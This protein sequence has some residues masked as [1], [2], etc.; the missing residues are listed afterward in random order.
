MSRLALALV[1]ALL[2]ADAPSVEADRALEQVATQVAEAHRKADAQTD[3][4]E[5]AKILQGA[6]ALT[7]PQAEESFHLR[8]D[9]FAQIA[10]LHLKSGDALRAAK[11]AREG[12]AEAKAWP[13]SIYG[14]Q[15]WLRLGEALEAA[16]DDDGAVN[17][18]Q[19]A[20]DVAKAALA[21]RQDA[22]RGP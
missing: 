2:A 11:D 9:L 12:L 17:A 4:I 3:P 1:A 20:I 21:A 18:Y 19:S 7:F 16:K 22:G 15:L 5:A 10:R 13:A 8:A 6:L 14:S